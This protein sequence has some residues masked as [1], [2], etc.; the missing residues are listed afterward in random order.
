M[1]EEIQRPRKSLPERKLLGDNKPVVFSA[2]LCPF[3]VEEREVFHVEGE[4]ASPFLN[5][6]LQLLLIRSPF[7]I[8]FLGMQDVIPSPP[9]DLS[10]LGVDVFVQK[11]P[12]S[13]SGEPICLGCGIARVFQRSGLDDSARSRSISS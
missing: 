2:L 3:I 5:R 8:Q 11:E 7:S 13:H 10:Q 4:K 9:Q 1:E 12:D 6:E